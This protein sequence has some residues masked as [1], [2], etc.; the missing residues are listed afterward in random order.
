MN[1]A[2]TV[3]AV[4]VGLPGVATALHLGVLAAASLFFRSPRPTGAVGSVRFIVLIPAYN[5]EKVIGDTLRAVTSDI[6]DRDQLVVV[7]DRCTDAT[8]A[9]AA[10]HGRAGIGARGARGTGTARRRVRPGSSTPR[11][12]SGTRW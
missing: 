11:V 1:L 3:A 12:S 10:R 8:A 6:R 9:I 5:E 7:A 2:L 4:V